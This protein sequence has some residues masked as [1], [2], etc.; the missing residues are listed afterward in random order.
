MKEKKKIDKNVLPIP[1]LGKELDRMDCGSSYIAEHEHGIL[2][3]CYNS[4]DIIIRPGMDAFDLLQD[5][6]KH[7]DDLESAT[8]TPQEGED[9]ETYGERL[10]AAT[11]VLNT[12]LI[13]FTAIGYLYEYALKTVECIT[14]ME[15]RL[16]NEAEL[17]EETPELNREFEQAT[18]AMDNIKE[19][20]LKDSKNS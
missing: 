8:Y 17:Q 6:I 15:T 2:Y 5:L 19:A 10:K 7:K 16:I 18:L 14:D 11:Y 1:M 9:V 20:I 12:P 13:A 3:H 4:L